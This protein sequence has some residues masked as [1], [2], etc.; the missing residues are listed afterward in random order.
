MNYRLFGI[1]L[2]IVGLSLLSC[3]EESKVGVWPPDDSGLKQNPIIRRVEPPTGTFS[4]IGEIT[5]FGENFSSDV[6]K[7][8][9]YVGIERAWISEAT[10]T[11]L[12]VGTPVVTGDSLNIQ[13][14]VIGAELFAVYSPY[15]MEEAVVDF[16][17]FGEFRDG[18]GLA[19]DADDTLYVSLKPNQVIA[20]SPDEEEKPYG[21]TSVLSLSAMRMGPGGYLYG[22]AGRKSIYRIPPGGGAS[23]EFVGGIPERVSDLDFDA[24]GNIFTGGKNA[25]LFRVTPEGDVKA[26]TTYPEGVEL[27][28]IRVF[29]GYVYVAGDGA[30]A[31]SAIWRNEIISSDS[32][33]PTEEVFD[34]GRFAGEDGALILALTFAADGDMYLGL[35]R[36]VAVYVLAP[37]YA[38][39][40]PEPL[41]PKVLEAPSNVLLWDNDQFLY[42]NRHPAEL[43][44]RQVFRVAIG[45][46]GAPYYGRQ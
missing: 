40:A 41:Y 6:N 20:I 38:A 4:G 23:E 28:S 44:E 37:P 13:V 25:I 12:V 35:D 5:I 2:F 32:L 46:E 36:D 9:V 31:D 21:T 29:D 16:G 24:S 34:W 15:K 39:A 33:G 45:K 10:D 7:N 3:E 11:M 43:T 18:N 14:T 26:I 17:G 8:L 30:G 27:R 22:V 42:I 1:I 19:M